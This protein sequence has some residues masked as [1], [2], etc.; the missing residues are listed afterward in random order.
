MEI[1][2]VNIEYSSL[3]E[4]PNKNSKADAV[5]VGEVVA[6]VATDGIDIVDIGGS[7]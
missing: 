5:D 6:D 4:D 7:I 1:R 3:Y 2:T